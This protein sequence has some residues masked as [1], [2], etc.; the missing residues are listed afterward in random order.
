[1]R[2]YVMRMK[3]PLTIMAALVEALKP[4]EQFKAMLTIAV[5]R[6]QSAGMYR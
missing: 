5:K 6:T 4:R 1:M 3:L 2:P